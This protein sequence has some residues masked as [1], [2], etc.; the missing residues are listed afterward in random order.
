MKISDSVVTVDPLLV[1][2]IHGVISNAEDGELPLFACT[3]G[4]P[5]PALLDALNQ[6]LPERASSLRM[7]DAHYQHIMQSRPLLHTELV[8]LLL[9]GR[10]PR[11]NPQHAGWLAHCIAAAATGSRHL[12]QDLGVRGRD[13]VSY[14]FRHYF[15][16][17]FLRNTAD[18]KWKRFLFEEL[19]SHAPN[20]SRCDKYPVCFPQPH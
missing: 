17:L 9:H 11:A 1:S 15:E 3:L 8:G 4:L 13:D 16:P 19:G 5:Q 2:A 18:L 20:C 14:L 6:C 10:S 12:W 7:P